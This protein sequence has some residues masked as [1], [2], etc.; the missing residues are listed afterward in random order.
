M[1]FLFPQ[2]PCHCLHGPSWVSMARVPSAKGKNVVETWLCSEGPSKRWRAWLYQASVKHKG[3]IPAHLAAREARGCGL[4]CTQGRGERDIDGQEQPLPHVLKGSLDLINIKP[5]HLT[6]SKDLTNHCYH[7]SVCP[8][9]GS[10][11][12]KTKTTHCHV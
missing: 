12:T 5:W 10:V 7:Y 3:V 1:L 4:S 2:R 9:L 11:T 6:H 8:R